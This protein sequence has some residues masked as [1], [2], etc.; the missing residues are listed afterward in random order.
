MI[1][2]EIASASGFS[3]E[4]LYIFY[5]VFMPD[6][7]TFEDYNEYETMGITKDETSEFNKR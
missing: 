4:S 5:E 1:T 7:W 2:G 6:G 3:E